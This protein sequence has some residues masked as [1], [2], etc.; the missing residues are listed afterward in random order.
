MKHLTCSFLLV[1]LKI[2]NSVFFLFKV[3]AHPD[4]CHL[5]PPPFLAWP[6]DTCGRIL[7]AG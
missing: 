6:P 1:C 2:T 4:F 3:Y 5:T 7:Y